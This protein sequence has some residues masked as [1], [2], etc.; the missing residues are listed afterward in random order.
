MYDDEKSN[1]SKIV[2]LSHGPSMF[3][4]PENVRRESEALRKFA[5]EISG[6]GI[7][8]Q[9]TLKNHY[10]AAMSDLHYVPEV[11]LLERLS[12]AL[13]GNSKRLEI[14]QPF[15]ALCLS[16]L[17]ASDIEVP[18]ELR[19]AP[20]I[21]D[22]TA[23]QH[24]REKR[25]SRP[26]ANKCRGMCGLGCWCWGWFCGD[27]CSHQGCYEHDICC[28]YSRWTSYCATPFR[29]G[30]SCSKFGGYPKCKSGSLGW[31]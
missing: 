26:T 17:K 2:F 25:C 18:D 8:Q 20:N 12:S 28:N 19:A 16:V 23:D 13:G 7:T 6:N 21:E 30:L 4:V 11:Q 27:C 29:Y 9:E 3:H 22:E 10:Q 14:L 1:E 31:K 5:R 15:H 24:E